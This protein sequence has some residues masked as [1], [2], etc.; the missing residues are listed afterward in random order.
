MKKAFAPATVA[1]V[2]CGFDVLGLDFAKRPKATS[3]N[4]LADSAHRQ[5]DVFLCI[6]GNGLLED[7]KMRLDRTVLVSGHPILASVDQTA[8]A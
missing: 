6:E 2:A 1:N 3:S 8:F 4:D 5:L 7:I